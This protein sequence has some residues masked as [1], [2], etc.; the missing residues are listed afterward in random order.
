MLARNPRRVRS[1]PPCSEGLSALVKDQEAWEHGQRIAAIWRFMT[2]SC[3]ES[4]GDIHTPHI[5]LVIYLLHEVEPT[6]SNLCE[7]IIPEV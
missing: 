1:R 5:D 7:R 3:L 6:I 2:C 4:W